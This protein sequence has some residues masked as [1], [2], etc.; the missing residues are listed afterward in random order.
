[1]SVILVTGQPGGGKTALTVDMIAHD[2]QFKGRPLFIMGIP[3]LAIEHQPCPPVTEWT[4]LRK[5]PEDETKD[6][7]YFTFPENAL[8]VIDEAQ[9]IYRP[10]PV[11]SKVPPEVAAFETHR[12]TGIDFILITQHAGLIDS[13]IRKLIGRHIH[14]RVTPLGRYRYEWTELG[15]PESV[16]S[17]DVAAKSRYVLPKRAFDLYKSSQLHTKI[18]TRMPWFVW[19]FLAAA[20]VSIGLGFYVYNRISGK[21]TQAD[22]TPK[23]LQ[24]KPDKM[25]ASAP[26]QTNAEFFAA[27]NPRIKGLHHT[28][29]KYDEVT[30][31]VDAPWPSACMVRAAW[32]GKPEVCRCIDQQGN[33]YATTEA[34]CR[35]FVNNGMFKDWGEKQQP[36]QTRTE[37]PE[38]RQAAQPTGSLPAPS[39]V[40]PAPILQAPTL[41]TTALPR[42]PDDSPWRFKG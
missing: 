4:E 8:I 39:A 1:M 26:G 23:T 2:E 10:R 31:P 12:H 17:R 28:A 38:A 6:L 7:A 41:Q 18:K 5:C 29:P 21:I 30:K 37:R 11:G 13:N 24:G 9:R 40:Q 25:S 35:D 16:S 19:L 3:D 20:M 15:D 14:I 32:K 22:T 42:V 36:Q 33:N 27:I 34:I